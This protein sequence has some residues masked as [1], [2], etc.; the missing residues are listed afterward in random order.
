MTTVAEGLEGLT[1]EEVNEEAARFLGLDPDQAVVGPPERARFFWATVK[2]LEWESRTPDP[3]TLTGRVL[4]LGRPDPDRL[5]DLLDLVARAAAVGVDVDDPV[6][7][8]AFHL[9]TLGAL[10]PDTLLLDDSGAPAGRS[11]TPGPPGAA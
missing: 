8:G 10:A 4:H 11:W 1:D 6:A 7:L 5:P 2:T 9:E 3:A